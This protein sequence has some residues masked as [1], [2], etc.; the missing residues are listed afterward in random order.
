[1]RVLHAQT[2]VYWAHGDLNK[3]VVK[4]VSTVYDT[5]LKVMLVKL[6]SS[7]YTK[8]IHSPGCSGTRSA[9]GRVWES[10][11]VVGLLPQVCT[12]LNILC[13]NSLV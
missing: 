12:E 3:Q 2:G 13:N 5:K 1:M 6:I 11:N 9:Q 4:Y 8:M 10:Y 7:L